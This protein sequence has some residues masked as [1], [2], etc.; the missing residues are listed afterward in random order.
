[1]TIREAIDRAD[2][3]KPNQYPDELKMQWLS[4]LDQR[5]YNDLFLT[6]EDNPY[7]PSDAPV[8]PS[9]EEGVEITEDEEESLVFP[10]TDDTRVLLAESPYD[11]LYPSYL[12]AKVDEC[13]EEITKYMNSSAIYNSQYRDYAKY[14]NRTHMPVQRRKN[15]FTKPYG[16]PI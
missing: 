6:H 4:E 2:L 5:I 1:M 12:K 3:I 14:Y 9:E 16:S 15:V 7:E 8:K 10:Y 11:V 13:Q